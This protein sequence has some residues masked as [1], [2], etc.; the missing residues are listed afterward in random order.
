MKDK[1]FIFHAVDMLQRHKCNSSGAWFMKRH[2]NEGIPNFE[3]FKEKIQNNETK[4]IEKIQHFSK[5]IEGSDSYW[6]SKRDE[7]YSWIEHHLSQGNGAPN[8]L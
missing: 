2:F 3:E 1:T 6:R 4:F 7:L 5:K 8:I